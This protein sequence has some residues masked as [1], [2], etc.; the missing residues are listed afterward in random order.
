VIRLATSADAPRLARLMAESALLLRYRTTYAGALDSLQSALADGDVVLV[1]GE[2]VAGF[3]WLS[4]APRILNHAA[5][6]R[7]LLVAQPAHGLGSQLL[8]EAERV[9]RERARHLYLL[10][11]T[12]NVAARRFYE[13]RGYRHVGDLPGL[14]WP[15]LDEALYYKTLTSA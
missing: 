5:Y 4:F 11:T 3:A 1:S 10:V 6:L 14:V 12:D 2:P 9:S 13:R 8:G 15:D 7:L